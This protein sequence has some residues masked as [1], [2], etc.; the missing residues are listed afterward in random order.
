MFQVLSHHLEGGTVFLPSLMHFGG[1]RSTERLS[2]LLLDAQLRSHFK[3][4]LCRQTRS[5]YI[6]R[7]LECLLIP[8]LHWPSPPQSFH[9][10][11]AGAGQTQAHSIRS[12]PS[13][14]YKEA[15]GGFPGD[16]VVENPPANAGDTG[17]S[18][19]PGRSL[20]PRSNEAH[21]P[22]LLSLH[23][24]AHKPQLLSPGA[25]TTEPVHHN[26]WA[27]APQLLSLCS[28]A[29]EPQLLSLRAA[30]TEA[31]M[32]RA[33]APQQEKPPQWEARAPRWRAAPAR[34]N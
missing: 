22:Q 7:C 9:Q 6:L 11:A 8:Q 23:S 12:A 3:T 27:R 16:A 24:R 1:N 20:M 17:L 25:T 34:R 2:K 14:S 10:C 19:G 28:R 31:R 29:H 26:Y 5:I 18:P 33:R 32:P 13:Q 30:T 4:H 21:E 15:T